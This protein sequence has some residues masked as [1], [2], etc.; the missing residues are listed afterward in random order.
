MY[1]L[2]IFEVKNLKRVLDPNQAQG[3]DRLIVPIC[4]DWFHLPPDEWFSD[5]FLLPTLQGYGLATPCRPSFI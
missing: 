5:F 1:Q 4:I 2:F 3:F